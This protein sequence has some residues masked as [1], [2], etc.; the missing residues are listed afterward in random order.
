MHPKTSFN[1]LLGVLAALFCLGASAH[2]PDMAVSLGAGSEPAP[3]EI[4]AFSPG[5]ELHY[6]VKALGLHA[7]KARVQVGALSDLDGTPAWPLVF[8]ARTD[9]IFDSIYS[10]RD[11]FVTWWDPETGRV[12]GAD[13]YAEER[14]KRH[15]SRSRLDHEKGKAEVLRIK[16]WN[17]QRSTRTYD[18]PA[19]TYDIAGA[20]FA[21]RGRPLAVGTVEE[22]QVFTGKKVFTLRCTVEKKESIKV[23]GSQRSAIATKVELGFDGN[24]ASK[25]DLR[26][27]FSDDD[28]RVP[29][30]V[31]A[32]LVLGSVLI[33]LEK[34][35]GL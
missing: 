35:R 27:W 3:P 18:I 21:L 34:S 10:V 22:M 11:R 8:Q 2:E 24:F 6:T 5:E 31:E 1:P 30:R 29:L 23:A 13:F 33:D 4:R 32:E 16:E 15:R 28:R 25:R 17:N 14:G 9:S 20:L 26:A 19:G 12:I 7:G